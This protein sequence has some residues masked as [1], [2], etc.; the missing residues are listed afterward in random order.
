MS[1]REFSIINSEMEED[2]TDLGLP[3]KFDEISL[4]FQMNGKGKFTFVSGKTYEGE[5]VNGKMHGKGELKFKLK[6]QERWISATTKFIAEIG[7]T[8]LPVKKNSS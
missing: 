8:E 3:R 1:K 2:I 6:F 5:F 4:K 7:K